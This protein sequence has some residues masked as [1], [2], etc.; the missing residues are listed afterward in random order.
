ME[1]KYIF[2][3]KKF[4][5]IYVDA[6]PYKGWHLTSNLSPPIPQAHIYWVWTELNDALPKNRVWKGRNSNPKMKKYDKYEYHHHV[7]LT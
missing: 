1:G 7:Q 2:L 3:T 5:I 6:T 4:Q